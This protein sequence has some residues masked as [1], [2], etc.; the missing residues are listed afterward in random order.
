MPW[1]RT[2][3]SSVEMESTARVRSFQISTEGRYPSLRD[4]ES[5]LCIVIAIELG[6]T[7]SRVAVPYK[8]NH[9]LICNDEGQLETPNYVAYTEN[10][11]LV[12][13]KAQHQAL[14]NPRNT[15]FDVRCV[16]LHEGVK[17]PANLP[18]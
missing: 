7:Y 10:G 1:M 6:E 15:I 12:G 3:E 5:V 13:L 9:E 8:N 18:S 14:Q 4:A 17:K 2:S 16:S 11:V